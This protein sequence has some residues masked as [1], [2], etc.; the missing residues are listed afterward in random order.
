MRGGRRSC[1]WRWLWLALLLASRP[2]LAEPLTDHLVNTYLHIDAAERARLEHG[3]ANGAIEIAPVILPEGD[4]IIDGNIHFGWPVA[5]MVGDSIVVSTRRKPGHGLPDNAGSGPFFVRSTDGGQTWS[6][7]NDLKPL[8][9][10][11]IEPGGM[12][13][14]GS[15]SSGRMIIKF[16]GALISEN[17]GESWTHYP[18]AFTNL[19]SDVHHFG[20]TMIEHPAFGLMMFNGRADGSDRAYI[21]YSQDEGEHWKETSWDTGL[22]LPKE[23]AAATWDGNILLISRE[24]NP[25]F[26]LHPDNGYYMLTQHLYR[27]KEGDTPA[28]IKFETLRTNIAGNPWNG[29]TGDP[30]PG[31]WAHDTADVIFNPITGR[32]ELLDSH[33][34]G[35]AGANT[36]TEPGLALSTLNLWSIDP[37]D[38]LDGSTNWQFETT[39]LERDD[40]WNMNHLD[41]LHP[42]GSVID[43]EHGVQHIFVYAGGGNNSDTPENGIFRITRSLHTASLAPAFKNHMG[44]VNG[45]GKVGLGDLQTI[46]DHWMSTNAN[47]STGDFNF[48]GIVNLADLQIL[49]DNW[50][51][52]FS[53]DLSFAQALATVGLQLPEPGS[54]ILFIPAWLQLLR[55]Q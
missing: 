9:P 51:Y 34:R 32:I 41:G 35:G 2:A 5:A 53:G 6:G 39:L 25:D 36:G 4:N 13:V 24:F 10:F 54:L 37:Q 38:L 18:T 27:Y 33:R 1:A 19:S 29:A 46:G 12:S 43:L 45:D 16:R 23:P 49:G 28:D 40:F 31:A 47:W 26:G 21:R 15:T 50:H 55:R 3:Q 44:D 20:P 48:D 11:G 30:S 42:G 8:M 14:I 7:M 17:G 52:G 22:F